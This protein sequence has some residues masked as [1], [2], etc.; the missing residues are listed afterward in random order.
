VNEITKQ[1]KNQLPK[2]ALMASLSFVT[3]SLSVIWLTPYLFKHL[4]AA[5]YGMVPLAGLFTQYASI[6]TAQLSV[7]VNRF[8]I[9]ELNKTD[10]HPNAIFNT[11]LALYLILIFI[12]VPVFSVGLIYVDRIFSIPAELKT[13]ALLLIG[14]SSGSFLF[15]L[16]SGVFGVAPL[17]KNRIDISSSIELGRQ[18]T[19]LVLIVFCFL[20]L[21][22]HLRYIGFVDLGLQVL[23]T[24]LLMRV[25]RKLCP[26]LSVDLKL[27]KWRILGPIFQMSFWTLFNSLG[28]LLFLRTDIWIINR[29]ISPVAAG[30]YAAVLMVV[31]FI[32]QVAGV[33]SR[34]IE[35]VVMMFWAKGERGELKKF[36]LLSTKIFA[37]FATLLVSI[38]CVF[39]K[40]VLSL[41]MNESFSQHAPLLV[42]MV[43][44]M[45][46]N[47]AVYPLGQLPVV[48]NSLRWPVRVKFFLGC[49]NAAG[50]YILGVQYGMGMFGVA[51]ATAIT[52]T[53]D[54]LFT[55]AYASRILGAEGAG[56]L[57]PMLVYLCV[58]T[59]LWVITRPPGLFAFL[60]VQSDDVW[61][62]LSVLV[63]LILFVLI[64]GWFLYFNP[65]ERGI[66]ARYFSLKIKGI[67]R[68]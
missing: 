23:V 12:Q 3:Y 40:D 9:L 43:F 4:G 67:V 49:V 20:F 17:A 8:L 36:L 42:V 28:V 37:L 29:F 57:K 33:G 19:R 32:R 61:Q 31:N 13:D 62:C 11:A 64:T 21:G 45:I 24:L 30:Q 50:S 5:A 47:V 7:A 51:I 55:S 46:V 52:L 27:V 63:S 34:Q 53:I 41:W 18:I 16:L 48:T 2:N 44:H 38:L 39:G 14:C 66:I 1:F 22:P 60:G 68:R 56:F 6:I 65:Q 26:D 10:G 59:M 35:P 54:S 25:C 58:E 15:S